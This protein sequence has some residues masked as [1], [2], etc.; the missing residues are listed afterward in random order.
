MPADPAAPGRLGLK[1]FHADNYSE[2]IRCWEKLPAGP[3][4]AATR[5]RLAEAYFRQSF[6]AADTR[7]RIDGLRQAVLRAPG[8]TRYRYHLALSL[9]RA[10]QHSEA[11]ECY[12]RLAEGGFACPG[13]GFLRGLAALE[14]YPPTPLSAME[15]LTDEDRDS[16]VPL[17]ALLSDQPKDVTSEFA[18]L[19]KDLFRG[20]T[21][22]SPDFNLWYGLAQLQLG[23]WETARKALQLRQGVLLPGAAEPTRLFYYALALAGCGDLDGAIEH[24]TRLLDKVPTDRVLEQLARASQRKIRA[25]LAQERL[26][27]AGAVLTR[28]FETLNDSPALIELDLELQDRWATEAARKENWG[29]AALCWRRMLQ[30]LEKN[31]FLGPRTPLLQNLAIALEKTAQWEEAALQWEELLAEMPAPPRPR[32]SRGP[33]AR[34]RALPLPGAADAGRFAVDLDRQAPK[35]SW[36]RRRIVGDYRQPGRPEEAI[37]WLRRELRERPNDAV[38]RLELA[39]ALR[40]SHSPHTV[41]GELK[42]VLRDD[43]GNVEALLILA[44]VGLESGRL[45]EAEDILRGL[46]DKDPR[47]TRARRGM[48]EL[49][50]AR[51]HQYTHAGSYAQGIGQFTAAFELEPER[52]ELLLDLADAEHRAGNRTSAHARLESLLA[53]GRP[54]NFLSVFSFWIMRDQPAPAKALL[55]RAMQAGLIDP[56]FLI[57]TAEL[58]LDAADPEDPEDPEDE[59][60]G[61]PPRSRKGASKAVRKEWQRLGEQL[62]NRA[63]SL[64]GQNPEVLERLLDA[65][66]SHRPQQAMECMK[67]L[68]ILMPDNP[69]LHAKHALLSSLQGN[70]SQA[71]RAL[72]RAERLAQQQQDAAVTTDIREI[73][74]SIEE[75]K[76]SL[77]FLDFLDDLGFPDMPFMNGFRPRGRK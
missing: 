51:G 60:F 39:D 7:L 24:W 56:H 2:A 72:Q 75:M 37:A 10:N 41:R 46:L 49:Y 23:R 62:L 74:E 66:L 53:G 11:L 61:P 63:E 21:R 59:I 69:V 68:L 12:A 35:R 22:V 73:R 48:V 45:E 42:K 33:A 44:E 13:F 38:L 30:C 5:S 29:A 40:Q 26:D 70:F 6:Q 31:P 76:Q 50:R 15:W 67:K 3:D 14:L 43:P 71:E 17:S 4:D 28:A 32:K 52:T 64:G 34:Q 16:L 57:Q 18:G 27:E 1:A 58:C 54:E 25:L 20:K 8:E 47:S 19:W 36:I 77:P 9:H 55:E 65:W